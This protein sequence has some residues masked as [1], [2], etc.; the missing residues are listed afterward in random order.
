MEEEIELSHE[1]FEGVMVL[2]SDR[3]NEIKQAHI[4]DLL[5]ID[6]WKLCNK[7]LDL[8]V[9]EGTIC[10]TGHVFDKESNLHGLELAVIVA[11]CLLEYVHE[12]F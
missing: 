12:F 9:G 5:I 2:V 3:G 11:V 7:I 4:K 8:L 6:L 10:A 1:G